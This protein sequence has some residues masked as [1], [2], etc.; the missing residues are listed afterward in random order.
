MHL[1]LTHTDLD[2]VSPVILN[3]LLNVKYDFTR[4][5]NYTELWGKDNELIVDPAI[6]RGFNEITVVDISFTE[7]LFIFLKTLFYKYTIIDHHKT[8]SFLKGKKGCIIDEEGSG[9]KLYL[10]YLSE[11]RE[12]PP[13]ITEFVNLVDT[14]D[15][16]KKD[17]PLWPKAYDLNR[18]FQ[19]K[20]NWYG[21]DFFRFT[22]F[23]DLWEKKLLANSDEV[24]F[25]EH[26]LK[27]IEEVKIK[28]DKE[29]AHAESHV[30]FF[31]D[32]KGF[33]YMVYYA[34]AKISHVCDYLL[35]KHEDCSYIINLNSY[36]EKAPAKKLI[37]GKISARS[38]KG[39]DVTSLNNIEGHENAGG[40]EM[41]VPQI[42]AF[43]GKE[44]IH[45]GYKEG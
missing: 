18:L 45:L 3:R 43:W 14:Y 20:I 36:N 40:G 25:D 39:F 32:D 34:S 13:S 7:D 37:N 9:T 2:G 6:F 35:G 23:I 41:T 27:L 8:S 30:K 16:W 19:K 11:G 44:N 5:I 29:I 21:K 4:C 17:S 28:E 26:D 24:V 15:R 33:K 38:R 22:P 31:T 10:D 42:Q 12:I 1:F